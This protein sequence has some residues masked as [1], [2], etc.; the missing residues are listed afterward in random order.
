MYCQ[1]LSLKLSFCHVLCLTLGLYRPTSGK[2]Y[3]SGYDISKDMVQVRKSLGLCPQDDILFHHL[4][5]S[6]HLYFYCV[7]IQR[8]ILFSHSFHMLQAV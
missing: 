8:Y 5:V 3:I 7:V 4:T 6:E 1:I 2:V